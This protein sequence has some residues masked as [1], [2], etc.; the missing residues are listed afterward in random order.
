M[1]YLNL[2]IFL[3]KDRKEGEELD[4]FWKMKIL[5]IYLTI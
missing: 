5:P 1:R 4:T 3:K 2:H